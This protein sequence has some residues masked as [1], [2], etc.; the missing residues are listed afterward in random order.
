[1]CGM[2]RRRLLE[3]IAILTAD[4][5]VASSNPPDDKGNSCDSAQIRSVVATPET[6]TTGANSNPPGISE[7]FTNG[8]PPPTPCMP[9]GLCLRLVSRIYNIGL[10]RQAACPLTVTHLFIVKSKFGPTG[11]FVRGTCRPQLGMLCNYA[12]GDV[13]PECI[14]SQ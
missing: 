2:G 3:R 4:R 12:H 7:R 13:L 9:Y 5:Q 6:P 10:T 11:M 14:G 1:M 8:D